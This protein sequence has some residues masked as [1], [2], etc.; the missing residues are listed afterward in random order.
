MDASRRDKFIREIVMEKPS[1]S[2]HA[3]K[4]PLD[5]DGTEGDFHSLSSFRRDAAFL[6]RALFATGRA[7]A[8]QPGPTVQR[9]VDRPTRRLPGNIYASH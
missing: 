5:F 4:F 1:S 7:R 8:V 6:R 2:F 9:S 3:T